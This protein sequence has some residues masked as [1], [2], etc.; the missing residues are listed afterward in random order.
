MSTPS[1]DDYVAA[2]DAR[3]AAAAGAG[4]RRVEGPGIRG[5]TSVDGS[6]PTQLLVLDDRAADALG[7]LVPLAPAG[8]VRVLD[9]APR[10]GELLRRN[11]GWEAMESTAM[12][13]RALRAVPRPPLPPG[14]AL[15]PVCRLP[16]DSSDGVPL[17]EAVAVAVQAM[18]PGEV[19]PAG[20][21]AYLRSL[22][23]GVRLFAAVDEGGVVRG[24]SGA[25]A[26]GSA[27]YVFFVNTDPPWQRRGVGLAMT[28]AALGSAAAAGA[29]RACL[30]ASG[31]G[32][33]LYQRL[34][35]T[36]VAGLTQFNPAS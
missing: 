14:L 17:S 16:E 9:A 6:A 22:P 13:C 30:D 31:A 1:L 3:C 10:C 35:F 25:R 33:Q 12:V 34:G 20:L 18:P 23:K 8:T 19:S 29:T 27:A 28:A 24:T 4:V 15:R 26:F 2:F 21:E 32:V 5:L 36:A 11:P 7:D